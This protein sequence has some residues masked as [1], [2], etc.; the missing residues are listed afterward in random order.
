[1]GPSPLERK[2]RNDILSPLFVLVPVPKRT[3]ARK[4]DADIF[5][6][7]LVVAQALARQLSYIENTPM[8]VIA[9]NHSCCRR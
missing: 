1:M 2:E 9:V 6:P 5:R 3:D 8:F 4:P 7:A